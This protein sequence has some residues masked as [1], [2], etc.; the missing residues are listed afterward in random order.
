MTS[1]QLARHAQR[2]TAN[3]P[4]EGAHTESDRKYVRGEAG[5]AVFRTQWRQTGHILTHWEAQAAYGES[6][7][8]EA[9]EYG[10]AVLR[11]TSTSTQNA[12]KERREDLGLDVRM[13]GR[14]AGLSADVVSLAETEPSTVAI[15]DLE[16]IAFTLGLDERFVAFKSDCGGDQDLGVRLKVLSQD[17]GSAVRVDGRNV[18]LLSEAA[19]V[20]RTQHR[21]QTWLQLPSELGRFTKSPDYGSYQSPAWSVGYKL[22]QSARVN[23]GLGNNPIPSMRELVEKRLGIPVIQANMNQNIAGATVTNTNEYGEEVRGIVLNLAGENRN[24]WV[25]RATLAH[26]LAHLLCDPSDALQKVRVDLYQNNQQNAETYVAADYVE[27]RANAFA[28]AFLAPIEA[29]RMIAPTPVQAED[30]GKVMTTFGISRT[31]A[32]YHISNCHYRQYLVPE[33]PLHIGPSDEQTAAE[34]FATDYFPLRG[35]PDQRRGKFAGL[36]AAA[37]EAG[38]ISEHTASLYLNGEATEFAAVSS[39][40]RELFDL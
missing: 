28:I 10:S 11:A 20:I 37:C 9:L 22:A 35:T 29:V 17:A 12:L 8:N 33:S 34:N 27:Q 14:A 38:Y 4:R 26:E 6:V 30:V 36:V 18:A 2:G 19:S 13:V 39:S 32:G 21:L 24:V 25:R 5:L 23:L 3:I 16:R 15:Q 31:A 1:N 7:I 40:L